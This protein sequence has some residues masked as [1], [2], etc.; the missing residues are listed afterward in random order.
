MFVLTSSPT[1][2]IRLSRL[3]GM[4]SS[5]TF[6]LS[7]LD[8]SRMLLIRLKRFSP[9]FFMVSAASL[10][11]MVSSSSRS[12]SAKPSIPFIGVRISWLMLAK[13][14]LFAML[15]ASASTAIWFAFVMACSS[16]SLIS[17]S[18][19]SVCLRLVMSLTLPS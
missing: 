18:S 5:S 17:F 1:S 19:I 12:R 15:A 2:S 11:S 7:T 9:L 4:V 10:C 13:N 14:P 3:K 16:C 8:R 6:L